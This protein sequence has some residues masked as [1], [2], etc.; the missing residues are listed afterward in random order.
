MPFGSS[1]VDDIA[2]IGVSK[3]ETLPQ[4]SAGWALKIC[5]PL[6]NRTSRQSAL[7]RWVIRMTAGCR[8]IQRRCSTSPV[9]RAERGR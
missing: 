7:T 1:S 5:R 6:I 9:S 4:Y 8:N 2:I 3:V